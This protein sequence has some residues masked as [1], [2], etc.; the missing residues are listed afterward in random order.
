[1]HRSYDIVVVGAG[2][3]G[4]CV[5]L[6]FRLRGYSVAL[7][8]QGTP[9]YPLASSTDISKVIRMA[10]G[11]DEVYTE[12][13]ELA[14]D[15]WVAWNE[16]FTRPLYHEDGV[17]SLTMSPMAPG[18]F[19]YESYHLLR[20]RGH[21][22]DRLD[23]KD[24][25]RR[26]PAWNSDR[27]VD[28]FFHDKGG[29]VESG[30]VLKEVIQW[31]LGSGVELVEATRVTG[32]VE[33]SGDIVGI[34]LSKN[35]ILSGDQIIVAAGS[36]TPLLVPEL[37]PVMRS[38]GQPVF[39]L[40]LNNTTLFKPPRFPVLTADISRT[41]WYG[42]PFH[43]REKVLKISNH[44]KGLEMHPDQDERVVQTRELQRLDDFLTETFPQLVGRVV[45]AHRCLYSDTLDEHFWIDHHPDYPRLSVAAGG[46]GHGFKFAPILGGLIADVVERKPNKF[47]S[48]FQWRDL[49]PDTLGEEEARH[50]G[51]PTVN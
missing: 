44:G 35:K 1:M 28:G 33:K 8:E 34:Q 41:G 48:R 5:A 37:I 6:E 10:Y 24:I 42:F 27:F 26:F 15:G 14:R 39:H 16:R 18:R 47:A 29:F 7:V 11:A 17:V 40:A 2:I 12:M 50:H 38:I 49:L 32:L 30:L 45:Y 19:E 51:E 23:G 21:K 43:P 36:W 46:S 25:S 31:A 22:L 9:P 3:F 4:A 20:K 13:A